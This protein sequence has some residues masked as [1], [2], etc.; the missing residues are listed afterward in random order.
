MDIEE[1]LERYRKLADMYAPAKAQ[2][3]YLEDYKK[4]CI[5]MLMKDALKG[6]H[7]SAAAQEREAAANPVY[8]KLLDDLKIAVHEEEKIRYHMKAVEWEI[9]IWRTKQANERAERRAYG[10]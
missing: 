5:A 9:E 7:A 8:I 4:S 2:R 6:G 10:A 3:G 1:L